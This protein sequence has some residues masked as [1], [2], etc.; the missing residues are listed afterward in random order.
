MRARLL[1][2]VFLF[3]IS[4]LAVYLV[5]SPTQEHHA[6]NDGTA[7]LIVGLEATDQ[8]T[9]QE[10]AEAL[11]EV[12]DARVL[13]ALRQHVEQEPDFHVRLAIHYAL[14]SQGDKSSI[15]ELIASL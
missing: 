4:C 8:Q 15:P 3:A 12:D 9:R 6:V 5:Y 1:L 2:F 7:G 10:A 14:A 13:P 11:A